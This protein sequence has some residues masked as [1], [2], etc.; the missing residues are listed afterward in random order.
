MKQA[1]ITEKYIQLSFNS[2]I[3]NDEFFPLKSLLA[4]QTRTSFFLEIVKAKRGCALCTNVPYT[5]VIT[6]ELNL[7]QANDNTYTEAKLPKSQ[8]YDLFCCCIFAYFY[9]FIPRCA[10]EKTNV[11][12]YKSYNYI[13]SAKLPQTNIG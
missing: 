10:S 11:L 9:V 8:L 7:Q 1:Q 5:T 13:Q 2:Y 6:I 4:L 3:S 12:P